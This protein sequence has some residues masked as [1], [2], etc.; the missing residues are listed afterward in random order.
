MLCPNELKICQTGYTNHDRYTLKTKHD[1][2]DKT[3]KPVMHFSAMGLFLK[4]TGQVWASLLFLLFLLC[5]KDA[6]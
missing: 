4:I 3:L 6:Y 5:K 1:I 2:I